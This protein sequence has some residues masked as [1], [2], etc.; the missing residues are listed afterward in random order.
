M[1]VGLINKST[2]TETGIG[3]YSAELQQSLKQAGV[4]VIEVNP[5]IPLP[6]GFLG[7]INKLIG[8]DIETF[9]YNYPVWI[10]Y[11][12]ADIF[13]LTS[14]NLATLMIFHKPPGR[15]VITVHD[16][17]NLDYQ[18]D[19]PLNV[20]LKIAHRFFEQL[21]LVG[22]R[23]IDWAISDS[24]FSK[25]VIHRLVSLESRNSSQESSPVE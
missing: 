23:R 6:K 20:F 21:A 24:N 7:L 2:K 1:R 3:R 17:I 4:D 11:P 25:T 18:S 5:I 19:L 12:E 22:I 10:R 8:W 16:L 13:H 9:F 15:T 14:Q